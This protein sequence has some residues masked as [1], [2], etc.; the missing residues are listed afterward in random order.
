MTPTNFSNHWPGDFCRLTDFLRWGF[1]VRFG[2]RGNF[3]FDGMCEYQSTGV[4][5][6]LTRWRGDRRG[7]ASRINTEG[8][9]EEGII[10]H[11]PES[12]GIGRTDLG[13]RRRR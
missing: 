9:E 3:L 5:G 12:A 11:S 4:D 8:T 6:R 1:L 10:P 7:A 2:A 13:K